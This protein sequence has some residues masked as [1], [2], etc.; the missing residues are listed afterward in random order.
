MDADKVVGGVTF[1]MLQRYPTT[2]FLGF[3][4]DLRVLSNKVVGGGFSIRKVAKTP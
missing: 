3:L 2:S 1:R 4:D